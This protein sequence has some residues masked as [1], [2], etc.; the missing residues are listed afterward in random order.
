[1]SFA[2]QAVKTQGVLAFREA[3]KILSHADLFPSA[4]RAVFL[5]NPPNHPSSSAAGAWRW[6]LHGVLPVVAGAAIYVL[7]RAPHLRVFG[8][9]RA[10]GLGDAVPAARAWA[11]PAAEHLPQWRGP[12]RRA[13]LCAGI[14]LGAGGELGQ[15]AGLVP[16]VWDPADLLLCGLAWA[17]AIHLNPPGATDEQA[18]RVRADRGRVRRAGGREHGRRLARSG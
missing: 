17:A 15:L 10:M 4:A 16:G 6:L 8:W 14:A 1:V 2:E 9:L 7:F 18:A 3:V 5:L 13:W 12:A 11:G